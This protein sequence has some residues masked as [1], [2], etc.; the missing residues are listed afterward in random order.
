MLEGLRA[1]QN[2]WPG[3]SCSCQAAAP[4][5]LPC[6][7]EL[8]VY[9]LMSSSPGQKD[10]NPRAEGSRGSEVRPRLIQ[11]GSF[12]AWV[13]WDPPPCCRAPNCL[14][15]CRLLNPLEPGLGGGPKRSLM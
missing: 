5:R 10:I 11:N 1:G 4:P 2:T 15:P 3:E 9:G 8:P 7:A 6:W 12:N 14:R 13:V